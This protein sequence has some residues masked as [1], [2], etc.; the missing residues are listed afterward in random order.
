MNVFII[1][2]S[3]DI[4]IS[5]SK[6][7]KKRGYNVIISYN[8]HACEIDDV[9]CVHMDVCN[10]KEVKSVF[11]DIFLKYGKIDVLIDM[12]AIYM[13][14]DFLSKSKSEF[15]NV[16]EVN[17]VGMFLCNR[18]YFK[19]MDNGTIINISSSDGIDTNNQYNIDYSASK[20]GVINLSRSISMVNTNKVICICPNW[21]DSNS[22]NMTSNEYLKFELNR[23]HQT[24]LIT[25]DEFNSVVYDAIC[26][27]D[28]GDVLRIDV[29]DGEL[30]IERI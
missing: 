5:L 16:L 21:I 13:D 30:W 2:G 28:N 24:R 23:T 17:L 25:L 8:R 12:A 9:Y 10:E 20:A 29:R 22:T 19:Y 3:S 26:N 7:L 11:K 1:G 27:Y 4:G 6:Y 15:M 14:N 18:E